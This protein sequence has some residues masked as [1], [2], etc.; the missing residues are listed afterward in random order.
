MES[1]IRGQTYGHQVQAREMVRM[2]LTK[3]SGSRYCDTV[4]VRTWAY[5]WPQAFQIALLISAGEAH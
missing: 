5:S 2:V 4:I 3:A 1:E